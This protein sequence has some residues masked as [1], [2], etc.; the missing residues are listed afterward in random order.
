[1]ELYIVIP[2]ESTKISFLP[3]HWKW[4]KDYASDKE[5]QLYYCRRCLFAYSGNPRYTSDN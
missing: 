1:M 5:N 2:A 4:V 3:F